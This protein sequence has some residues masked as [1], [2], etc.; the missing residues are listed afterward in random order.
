MA[1]G[2]STL[3]AGRYADG[4][5]TKRFLDSVELTQQAPLK[6]ES[7]KFLPRELREK[8][9][10]YSIDF[11]EGNPLQKSSVSGF[12]RRSYLSLLLRALRDSAIVSAGVVLSFVPAYLRRKNADVLREDFA[13]GS[14]F[15]GIAS[16]VVAGYNVYNFTPPD[17]DAFMKQLDAELRGFRETLNVA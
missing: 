17:H 8:L 13:R 2:L 11:A 7:F 12:P 5:S 9:S 4:A 15:V 1:E 10:D 3:F 14:M 6:L 16:F